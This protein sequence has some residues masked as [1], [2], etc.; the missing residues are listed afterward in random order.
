MPSILKKLW[1]LFKQRYGQILL[2]LLLLIISILSIRWGKYL[3][4]NDNYSPELNPLLSVTRYLQNPAWRS[5]RVLGFA[6][7]SEQAD[8]FRSL[9]FGIGDL[10]LPKWSLAQFFSLFSLCVGT[11]SM[12]TLTT[13]FIRDF[14]NT[15]SSGY[16]FFI[17]GLIY[18]S[19]L[20][21][22]WVFNFNMM[23]YIAQFG[24]LPL[25]LL[26]IYILMKDLTY[27]RAFILLLSSILFVSVSV[28]GTLFFVNIV[29]IILA[30][31]Y[32]GY[33]HRVK[34]RGILKG[35]TIFFVVQ[36][37]WLLPFIQYSFSTS[38]DI[39]D[40]YTNRSI[41]SNT[42][43]LEAQMLTL[44][45]AAKF[46]TRLLGTVDNSETNTFI[47]PMSEE[48]MNYDF[49]KV[50]GLLPLFL[51]VIGII[52]TIFQR[53][54]KLL[55]IWL[56]MFGLLFILKNQNPPFGGIYL[57]LQ[58]NFNI[59]KQVFRWVSSKLSQQ[60]LILLT[61]TSTIGF[62]LILNFL[63]SF[64]KKLPRYVFILFTLGLITIPLLFYSE[65][66]F[67]GDLFTKRAT[68]ALPDEYYELKNF[69]KDD[70]HSRIYYAPPSNNG[71]F[72]EYDWGFVG[73]QFISYV[74]PNPVMDM[75]LAI[76]SDVGEKAMFEI[77]NAYEGGNHQSVNDVLHKYSVEYVL[78]D[79]SLVKGRY[80]HTLDWDIL[81][82]YSK[83]WQN[84]W[85]K[86]FLTLYK[87]PKVE[88]KYKEYLGTSSSL[89][90]GSFIRNLQREP[91]I[92]PMN[93]DHSGMQ[94][95]NGYLIKKFMYSGIPTT[96]YSDITMSDILQSPV[97]VRR[98]GEKIRVSPA[99]PSLNNLKN[100]TY[101]E[102]P[103]QAID[104][105]YYVID[106]NVFTGTDL[107]EGVFL[108][109]KYGD[110]KEIYIVRKSSL[111][112]VPLTSLMSQSSPGDCS[113]GEYSV[114]PNVEQEKISSGFK[115]EG[116]SELP[117]VY[118]NLRL[119]KRM[120]YVGSISINWETGLDTTLGYCLYSEELGDCLNQDRYIYVKETFGNIEI[121]IPKIIPKGDKVSLTIYA[122]NPTSKKVNIVVRNLS[123]NL[124]G[125]L[126]PISQSLEEIDLQRKILSLDKDRNEMLLQIPL[127]YGDGSYV[128]TK[129]FS[130]NV[131]WRPNKAE[132]GSLTYSTT[133]DNGMRQD[134][135]NQYV[136]QYITLF[137]KTLPGKYLWYWSGENIMNIPSTLCLTYA[138]DDKCWVDDIFYQG[139]SKNVTRIFSSST[140]PDKQLD[141]S[142]NSISFA[143]ES[144]NVLNKLVVM[145]IPDV[146]FN[147][148]YFS[149]LE[150][151][152]KEIELEPVGKH[153]LAYKLKKIPD[154]SG[155]YNLITIPEAK[156]KYWLALGFGH[157]GLHVLGKDKVVYLNGWK[158]GWDT[159]GVEY[160]QFI[161]FYWP[162]VLSYL[163]YIVIIMTF[164]YLVIK[165]FR[166]NRYAR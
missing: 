61:L 94:E 29:L 48:Y 51:S 41:T 52:F 100:R 37:F 159:D 129:R 123:L 152:Y 89:Q 3:L 76:G 161:V 97:Y 115:L 57:W 55:P 147:T 107:K 73:S 42:I 46:Y 166:E 102:Y 5:Y 40:S 2:I 165:L 157:D 78:V 54:Y 122:L 139:E 30:F 59:F 68:V 39:V 127:L 80:G 63:S 62:I 19:T 8:I 75:S 23:P 56:V 140:K 164:M 28:I 1:Y 105:D 84:V 133:Y 149:S 162:N 131:L 16:I 96:L 87:L 11:I 156:S 71:Y 101:K 20:W 138:G 66:M 160:S 163:G 126:E 12:A 111:V 91:K 4:S 90:N 83:G 125:V 34:I 74:I 119:D 142:Y 10:F 146:W 106:S 151:E 26:S 109:T 14:V 88:T 137:R 136:N 36:L 155:R 64:F 143:N 27:T 43:D 141:A 9:L 135:K 120:P 72:R 85:S 25:L 7:D 128:Y 124:S 113:G 35:F 38:K 82:G 93:L 144:K 65:Y 17:S 110:L 117:C 15:K 33:L 153:S 145:R 60:Y 118:S 18:L 112:E 44:P 6:S 103:I 150:N 104:E 154:S 99:L 81:E 158:Q 130:D 132:D 95:A 67:K 45:N 134:V 114:L 98:V 70:T 79:K 31:I 77:K 58:D 92:V 32:F 24:F 21:T 53:K 148:F 13:Y 69:L 116:Y 50:V 108:T 121:P 49:Y 86:N 47:F 22:A